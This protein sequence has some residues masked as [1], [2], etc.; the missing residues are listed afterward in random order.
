MQHER[1]HI[2]MVYSYE[3]LTSKPAAQG[4][5]LIHLLATKLAA[6]T[7]SMEQSSSYKSC[8]QGLFSLEEADTALLVN[9][10]DCCRL[11]AIE[12]IHP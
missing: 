3:L 2:H 6:K 1:T 4:I 8:Q 12:G 11:D 9:V 5:L 10:K 7:L